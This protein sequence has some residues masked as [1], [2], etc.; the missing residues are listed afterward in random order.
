MERLFFIV[1]KMSLVS[2]YCIGFVLFVRLFLKKAPKIY[3]YLLWMIVFIRLICPVALESPVS[4]VPSAVT[5][6]ERTFYT[7]QQAGLGN[8]EGQ[9]AF[10]G[11]GQEK[12]K[13]EHV[14][15]GKDY[16]KKGSDASQNL[17]PG[18]WEALGRIGAGIWIL[19][20]LPLIAY[21][22]WSLIG[23]KRKLAGSKKLSEALY[24]RRKGECDSLYV[25][26]QIKTAFVFGFMKPEIYL[27]KGMK[28]EEM[29]YV[30]RHE[31]IHVRRWD[32]RTRII[33]F[34]IVCV[35]WFNP[36]VWLSYL[37]MG[38]DME[39]SCD[40][41]VLKEMGAEIKKA[42][43]NSL[44]SLAVCDKSLGKI[45]IA[46][47]EQDIRNRILNVLS[48][49]KAKTGITLFGM[50]LC[51]AVAAGLLTNQ[52][53][54]K[55]MVDV[56]AEEDKKD[57]TE[58]GTEEH[59]QKEAAAKKWAEAFSLRNGNE[60]YNLSWDKEAFL[61]WELVE[62]VNNGKEYSFGWSSPWPWSEDYR[63]VIKDDMA[64]I[65]YYA[66]TSQPSVNVWKE[67]VELVRQEDGS[68]LIN[69]QE[70]NMYDEIKTKEEFD[71]AYS[72]EG[73]YLYYGEEQQLFTEGVAYQLALGEQQEM[74]SP[75]LEPDTSA[76]AMLYLS[77]GNVDVK[78]KK[79]EEALISYIFSDGSVIEIPMYRIQNL[80][81]LTE[82]ESN[83]EEQSSRMISLW[84]PWKQETL[85][86]D[87]DDDQEFMQFEKKTAGTKELTMEEVKELP[88]KSEV[89][90]EDFEGYSNGVYETFSDENAL[91]GYLKFA[92]SYEGEDYEL[93][94][95]YM[96]EDHTIDTISLV[97]TET[98]QLIL[99]KA[100]PKYEQNQDVEGFLNLNSHTTLSDYVQY[101]L[102]D[103]LSESGF[104]AGVG[105]RGGHI[106]YFEGED[107]IKST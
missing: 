1:I 17:S 75:Y 46:F 61:Q 26:E 81:Q 73:S 83:G 102:P 31:Q 99:L 16:A 52:R 90:L 86:A 32:Y 72:V 69:H 66:V 49:K 39:M 55:E 23:M 85:K 44:L 56:I 24:E 12:E 63:I 79:A 38:R 104:L 107:T 93:L 30:I 54:N 82:E 87:D 53:D 67:E 48:Y 84:A 57:I 25:S 43:S 45:P 60:L 80:V 68:Y 59:Q 92:L 15:N 18:K 77:G 74:Y 47:G 36:F 71:Q 78:E 34:L 62:S 22:G 95:S 4:L 101:Q 76:V 7:E 41:R 100:A 105:S 50:I 65:Y 98:G 106:F 10:W 21:F 64:D 3:S 103:G 89:T 14:L 51:V 35:H 20:M 19:G 33:A 5:G 40:E 58:A 88:Y 27:P 8:R 9:A 96:L 94:I 2:L 28:Q 11:Q 97:R 13:E 42:Y 91:N 29:E 6:M 37:L 70:L